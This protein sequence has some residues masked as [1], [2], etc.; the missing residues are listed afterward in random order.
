[1]SKSQPGEVRI[2]FSDHAAILV[3]VLSV[4]TAW[5]CALGFS[6]THSYDPA[7]LAATTSGIA[8][9]L[10]ARLGRDLP[11]DVPL[12][13]E[14]DRAGK[15]PFR[16][17]AHAFRCWLS[18]SAWLLVA[19]V[20]ESG[21]ASIG[22]FTLVL[23][24]LSVRLVVPWL[25][26]GR[27]DHTIGPRRIAG[28]VLQPGDAADPPK[29]S[30]RPATP[31]PTGETPQRAAYTAPGTTTLRPPAAP[32][33]R[34]A[35]D[36]NRA[37]ITR[38]LN[39][40][41]LNARVTGCI[42]G[43]AVLQY[44]ITPGPGVKVSK[45]TDLAKNFAMYLQVGENS[46]RMI[47]PV[48]GRPVIGLEIPRAIEDRQ[49]I[50]I[51]EILES[52]EMLADPHPLLVA[53]GA[54]NENNPVT[55]AIHKAPHILIA[56]ATG[57]GKSVCLN[58]VIVSILTRATPAQVRMIMIDPKRVELAPYADVPHLLFPIIK[59]PV[60]AAQRLAWVCEKMDDR[61]DAMAGAGVSHIDDYNKLP[62]ADPWPYWLV[63]VDE[64]ADLMMLSKSKTLDDDIE[65]PDVEDCIVRITQLARACGIHLILATQRP[66]V[67][68]VTGLIKANVP[69]RIAFAVASGT[70]SRVILD[71]M[72][73]E[74]LGG[75][76][77]GLLRTPAARE[78][79]RFQG[80]FVA[81]E[82]R[83]ATI[84]RVMAQV[85][86]PPRP[87]ARKIITATVEP[88]AAPELNLGDVV[89]AADLV[90]STQ[91]GSTS[92]I[93]RKLR[94][95]FAYAGEIMHDLEK[96]G[97]VGPADGPKARDVLIKPDGKEA[98][99]AAI[100]GEA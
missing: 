53:L 62:D 74:A 69:V 41:K 29:T 2:M 94:I 100:R 15:K 17:H 7:E 56:G 78:L 72:G 58:G 18:W 14:D 22:F 23:V 54:D 96:R 6:R 8:L 73:A 42:A 9:L 16:P 92:M 61:Y 44:Q 91:F 93:Q 82:D 68:V 21:A 87:A 25:F 35:V 99:L 59:N 49:V 90:I 75:Q 85:T 34:P 64:L 38:I 40:F 50:V 67:G 36:T 80:A 30:P 89:H 95:G 12:S 84:V 13:A 79:T 97:V 28:T 24:G 65:I 27:V 32:R 46:V 33:P 57:A 71:A 76:G 70:D 1:M 37:A 26:Y 43:P 20:A 10:L 55:L 98:A 48:P 39:E 86:P 3:P 60:E 88:P 77:D 19:S 66:T 63:I 47:A 31:R 51:R 5:V 11:A 52:P 45:I 83:D 4:V 81:K